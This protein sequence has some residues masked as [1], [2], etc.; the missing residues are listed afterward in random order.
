[1]RK[2]ALPIIF[3]VVCSSFMLFGPS[4]G[5]LYAQLGKG[6]LTGTVTDPTGAVI[7]NATV[8]LMSKATGVSRSVA[9]NASGI[10]RFGFT[11]VG[12]Y[13]LRVSAPGFANYEVAGIVITVGQ[14]VTRN[15]RLEVAQ[16]NVQTVTVESR[17]VQ[18]VNTANA[19]IS[20][21][22]NNTTI[23]NLPLEI[24]D[25]T[26]FVNLQPGAVPDVFNGSTRGAA[27]NG[28]RGGTGNFM[29]DGTD[30]NDYGQGG[31]SHNTIGTLPGGITSISPDAVQEF[32][33]VT[34]NFSAQYGRQGGFE[35]DVVLK[36]GKNQI[37]GSAFEYNRNSTTTANDFFSN[38]AGLSDQLIRN[39]F[40]GSFG[41]PIKKDTAWFYGAVEIQ[42]LRQTTPVTGTAL[43]QSFIDFVNNGGFAKFV[44]QNLPSF[45]L[46]APINCTNPANYGCT[47]GP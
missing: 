40:G 4:T 9:S 42:R 10:Y 41:G 25:A 46:S 18:M 8:S 6:V 44:N 14:T 38:K 2:N 37:H 7:P 11:D 30:N 15:V 47:L 21:L 22:V 19:E 26:A 36:S 5:R 32:R 28:Q 24:R 31:R 3:M 12:A 27:V 13:T 43:R 34:N 45:G 35:T 29:V 23:E 1:M 39:Q 33:V 20:G 17:G 16:A